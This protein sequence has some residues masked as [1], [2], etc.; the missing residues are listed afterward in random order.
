MGGFC[1]SAKLNQIADPVFDC[2]DLVPPALA[3]IS[4][5]PVFSS[6]RSARMAAGAGCTG[7]L[8]AE[9]LIS[10]ARCWARIRTAQVQ[11]GRADG[12]A[13]PQPN[14][15]GGRVGRRVWPTVPTRRIVGLALTGRGFKEESAQNGLF[16]AR[17]TLA[18]LSRG[19]A[20]RLPSTSRCRCGS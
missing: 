11:G 14:Y 12:V 19:R 8:P 18:R 13:F 2:F 6:D 5:I 16:W 10:I 7:V 15:V 17:L 20:E 3:R 4:S 1:Q 9:R